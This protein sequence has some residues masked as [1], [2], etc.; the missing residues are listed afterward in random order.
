MWFRN[1][2]IYSFAEEVTLDADTLQAQLEKASFS[3]CASQEMSSYGWTAPMGKLNDALQ[4][5]ASGFTLLCAKKEERILPASVVRDFV[6]ERV[7][8]IE[9][10]QMRKV[11]K[12]ERDEIKENVLM[13]LT[14]KAFTRSS[15]SYGILAPEQGYLL[16]DAAS[17]RKADE[18]TVL[19]RK[20]L[21]SLPIKPLQVA[22]APAALFTAWLDGKA[23]LPPGLDIGHEC[24][25]IAADDEDGG[26]VR[27]SKQQLLDSEEIR[28]H[29]KAGKHVVKLG[30]S[31]EDSLRFVL[32]NELNLK[33]LRF[34]DELQ[35]K[36]ADDGSADAAAEFD[37]QFTL[38]SL[39]FARFVPALIALF[40]GLQEP[41][42]K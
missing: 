14:P 9:E 2:M 11:R 36:A 20:T 4:H 6:M 26:V 18:F 15:L 31:W 13:E 17:A 25:L 24:E 1:L 27:C 40:G 35:E 7:T 29:L 37:A 16:L 28:T 42:D 38:A 8:A 5:S 23:D 19:L 33:K 30:L 12:K 41:E 39:E 34:S 32:D 10:G 3:P 22:S 21:G